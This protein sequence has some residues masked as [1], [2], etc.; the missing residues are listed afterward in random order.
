[1]LACATIYLVKRLH[2]M[3]N[4]IIQSDLSERDVKDCALRLL[5]VCENQ[6]PH[7]SAIKQ[8]YSTEPFM[9]A[10]MFTIEN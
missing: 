7:M 9:R 10:S 4:Y 5:D 8:K 1:M 2:H 6:K 3:S